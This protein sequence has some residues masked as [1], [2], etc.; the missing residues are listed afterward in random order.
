[1]AERIRNPKDILIILEALG[2]VAQRDSR[3]DVSPA[4]LAK[5]DLEKYL[6]HLLD[7]YEHACGEKPLPE[8]DAGT[9]F[10]QIMSRFFSTDHGWTI[11]SGGFGISGKSESFFEFLRKGNC[12]ECTPAR[13]IPDLIK[14][15]NE[16]K[17]QIVRT[18]VLNDNR[19]KSALT[20]F[21]L[22]AS[23]DSRGLQNHLI[24]RLAKIQDMLKEKVDEGKLSTLEGL[25]Q[26]LTDPD[27]HVM[28]YKILY[29]L[30]I[31][32]EGKAVLPASLEALVEAA[33]NNEAQF[34]LLYEFASKKQ[35]KENGGGKNGAGGQGT[36]PEGTPPATS[37]SGGTSLSSNEQGVLLY[38]S[39]YLS[40][41][42][43]PE[44]TP[45]VPEHPYPQPMPM[46]QPMTPSQ[47]G[48]QLPPWLLPTT[49]PLI[50]P[51]VTPVPPKMLN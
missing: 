30:G 8:T 24:F 7:Q 25:L 49:M 46:P 20:A 27:L 50:N 19:W 43:R 29:L 39:R 38:F 13:R 40:E 15:F 32:D 4:P 47:P 26:V 18:A 6:D 1:M 9:R 11:G 35:D 14:A 17:A 22:G 36:P 12:P 3:V 44:E 21:G 37:G 41:E 48:M 51:I 10:T 33:K 23:D 28:G 2:P 34:D 45:R 31:D 5:K 42:D 16:I